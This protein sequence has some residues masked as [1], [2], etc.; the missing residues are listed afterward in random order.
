TGLTSYWTDDV[1]ARRVR[2]T[3]ATAALDSQA[4]Q[5]DTTQDESREAVLW[6]NHVQG[7]FYALFLGFIVAFLTLLWEKVA[8]FRS[9]LSK[10]TT[11]QHC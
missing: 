11:H 2:E 4:P 9:C 6:L 5:G 7:A 3:R 10:V 1:I 8:H